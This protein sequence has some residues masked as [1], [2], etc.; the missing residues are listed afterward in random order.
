MRCTEF[1]LDVPHA[2]AANEPMRSGTSYSLLVALVIS[3]VATCAVAAGP[4]E[5]AEIVD[6]PVQ[7]RE[8]IRPTDNYGDLKNK[9]LQQS[10]LQAVK[11]TLGTEVRTRSQFAVEATDGEESE[12]FKELSAEKARGYIESYRITKEDIVSEGSISLL[13]LEVVARVCVPK[14]EVTRQAVLIGDFVAND[15]P[16]EPMRQLLAA[17][18][19]RESNHFVVLPSDPDGTM[20]DIVIAG[21]LLET[22]VHRQSATEVKKRKERVS[23]ALSLAKRLAGVDVSRYVSNDR[24]A[25]QTVTVSVVVEASRPA[26]QAV[27]T[28]TETATMEVPMDAKIDEVSAQLMTK[29]T[30]KA[31]ESIYK[32]LARSS[33]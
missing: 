31:G 15:Q 3:G 20:T 5:C 16:S 33:P 4:H 6:T 1:A 24:R 27:I 10:L 11:Q 26:D 7:N 8:F 28:E 2:P 13:E 14:D 25:S 12:R 17:M 18:F 29:A 9:V 19:S 21:R 23:Q 32:R 22:R 30:K